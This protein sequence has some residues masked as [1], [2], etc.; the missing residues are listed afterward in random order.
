MKQHLLG[1]ALLALSASAWSLSCTPTPAFALKHTGNVYTDSVF[2]LQSS[3]PESQAPISVTDVQLQ[4]DGKTAPVLALQAWPQK[5]DGYSGVQMKGKLQAGGAYQL[6][7]KDQSRETYPGL[8]EVANRFSVETKI[9][10][11]PDL[12]WR[13]PPKLI[14]VGYNSGTWGDSG[15]VLWSLQTTRPLQDYLVVIQ[16]AAKPDMANA[17]TFIVN[18]VS[19]QGQDVVGVSFGPCQYGPEAYVFSKNSTVWA[20]FD[21]LSHDG[22]LIPWQGKPQKNK[23]I[24]PLIPYRPL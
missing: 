15:N 17:K 9:I 16:L 10:A 18:P 19:L 2:W 5:I 4:Q 12:A 24:P 23:L 20:R 7:L 22:K 1:M 13:E 21:L 11:S 14:K 3:V 6:V 8:S